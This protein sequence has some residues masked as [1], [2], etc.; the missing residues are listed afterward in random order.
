MAIKENASLSRW[1]PLGGKSTSEVCRLLTQVVVFVL[2]SMKKGLPLG[3]LRTSQ[4]AGR[5]PDSDG[6]S[7]LGVC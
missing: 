5:K 7:G 6:G 4:P 1:S 3:A 2:W